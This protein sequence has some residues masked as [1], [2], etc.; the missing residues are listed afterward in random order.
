MPVVICTAGTPWR[1]MRSASF[2][3]SMSPSITATVNDLGSAWMV[4]SSRLVLP[5]PGPD[6][7][8]TANTPSASK[9]ARLWSAWRSFSCSR[10]SSTSMVWRSACTRCRL[11]SVMLHPQLSHMVYSFSGR[12]LRLSRPTATWA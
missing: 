7:R 8:F 4:A 3:V 1:R 10:S 9:C 6:I 12:V 2:S 5:L 11:P